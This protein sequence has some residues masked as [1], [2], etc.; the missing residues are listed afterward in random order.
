MQSAPT[1]VQN[2]LPV[3]DEPWM[4]FVPW[5]TQTAPVRTMTAPTT[6]LAI[7]RDAFPTTERAAAVSGAKA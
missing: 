2:V 4:R 6:R 5:P 1:T 3:I 7:V